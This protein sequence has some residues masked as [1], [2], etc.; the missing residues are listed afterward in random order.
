M[1]NE[2]TIIVAM[3]MRSDRG[4]RTCSLGQK[5]FNRARRQRSESTYLTRAR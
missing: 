3:L 1:T 4:V 2:Q 5:I